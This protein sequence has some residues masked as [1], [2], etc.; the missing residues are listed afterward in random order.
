[1]EGHRALIDAHVERW[2]A[3]LPDD[4]LYAPMT[5]LMRLPAKRVRPAL[6][7][8]GC[9]LF[10]GRAEDALDE[11]LGIELFHNFT[12]MHD[13]IMDASPLRR[14]RPSVHVKWD[15][16][17]AILSGDAMLVKA[18]QAM[19]R[20]SNVLDLFGRCA[21][22]VCE[23]QQ[24]DMALEQR[25]DVAL[26]E[27]NDMIRL[28]TAVLLSCALQVGAAIGGASPGDLERIGEFGEHLG[29]AFQLR[30]DALDAFGDP[31][32]VGK[33]QGGDLLAGKKTWLLI[34]G[35]EREAEEGGTA[36]HDALA[37]S[38]DQRNVTLMISTLEALGVRAEAEAEVTRHNEAALRALDAVGALEERKR[39]LRTLAALLLDRVS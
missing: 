3:A 38:P 31:G 19:G 9:E 11:A 18:Y 5:Y 28:K 8:M 14:G 32:K 39:P 36:L 34:R 2:I 1:M 30:D 24:R 37:M 16:N 25:R 33:Q 35:L 20:R 23:G 29:L 22:Q 21:L 17:T 26:S 13:D 27:Y 7:L 10:G 4:P 15:V 12:L 6:T